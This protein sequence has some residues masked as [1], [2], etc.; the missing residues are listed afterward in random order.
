MTIEVNVPM[1]INA[2]A[3]P[4]EWRL[5]RKTVGPRGGIRWVKIYS[6]SAT[7]GYLPDLQ[8]APGEYKITYWSNGWP[9]SEFFDV[10]AYEIVAEGLDNLTVS[11]EYA[12]NSAEH[13]AQVWAVEWVERGD[14]IY[15][16]GELYAR[17]ID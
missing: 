12:I 4:G 5:S 7:G 9:R 1:M 8:L 16:G 17:R 3:N 11:Y 15:L 13:M 14:K 2:V 10:V 6:T